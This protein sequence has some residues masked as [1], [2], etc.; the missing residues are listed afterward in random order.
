MS[1]FIKPWLFKVPLPPPTT[2]LSLGR[3]SSTLTLTFCWRH[4]MNFHPSFLEQLQCSTDDMGHILRVMARLFFASCKVKKYKPH[5]HP[6][7]K[8]QVAAQ[9]C[10]KACEFSI[11]SYITITITIFLVT[12]YLKLLW[13]IFF[14]LTMDQMT[15]Y[16]EGVHSWWLTTL[17]VVLARTPH[18]SHQPF[19]TCSR[20]LS[21][22]INLW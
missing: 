4:W 18:Q 7:L 3:R 8:Y 6:H 5:A 9:E 13:T 2:K 14:Q 22:V 21:L 16:Y 20:Q 19:S 17:L 11:F 15:V 1:L 10:W 12:I